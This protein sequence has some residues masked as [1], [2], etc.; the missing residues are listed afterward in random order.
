MRNLLK[1]TGFILIAVGTI[2]LLLNEFI[3]DSSFSRAIIFAVVNLIGLV[4]LALA[5]FGIREKA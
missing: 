2:C 5:H 3:W 1:I 4:S